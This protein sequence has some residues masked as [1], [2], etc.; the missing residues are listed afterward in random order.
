MSIT[1]PQDWVIKPL[2]ELLVS[3]ESGS[4]PKGGV[5]G[6]ESGVPSL[7]GEHLDSNGGFKFEKIKYVP[8]A[9]AAKMTRGRIQ[10]GDILI[11]KDGATTGKTSFVGPSFP[12]ADA[13]INEHVFS[14]RCQENI[15]PKYIFYFL[16]SAEGNRQILEDF[17]GAAQGGISQR[18]ADIVN[19]PLAPLDQQKRIVAE[20]E[21][22][23]SRLDEA[24]ANLK[25][26]KAN[27]K[28]YKATVLKAAVEGR[29]VETE[30]SIARREGRSLPTP[31]PGVFYVYAIRCIDD[32]IYIGHTDNLARRWEEHL[33][34]QG[35]DWTKQHKPIQIVRYE[36]YTSRQEA[37]DREKWLKTGYGRKWIKRE[38]EAGRTRQVGY[39]TGEQLLQRILDTRRQQWLARAEQAGGKGKGKYKEPSAPDTT[40]L[41]ELPEGWVVADLEQLTSSERIIC[42]GIL[43]PKENVPDGVLYVKVRDMKGDK[44]DMTSLQRTSP[45][46]AAKY[47][48]ASLKT[49]DILLAIRGT[50]GRIAEVPPELDG[51]NITQDTAR[52]AVSPLMDRNYVAWF[53]RSLVAQ[54]FFKKVARGVAVKGVN[55]ADV[56]VCPVF[57]PSLPEQRRIVAEVERRLSIVDEVADQ[58]DVNLMRADR[59][60]Q[61]VLRRSFGDRFSRCA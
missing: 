17:R 49:G 22:Q 59:L 35:A 47:T 8:K 44:V 36:E 42:Y 6:I 40:D 52:L 56:R 48:K 10:H 20:I 54:N 5:K 15:E 18:F 26:V 60:R 24:V 13:V 31:R 25:R 34:G 19:V 55:I 7:G 43:M 39:E 33:A 16:Y 11:V 28:R 23:L 3:F 41:P 30:A 51:G 9:F 53:L 45:D 2:R 14:C 29:L 27:L 50:Y 46:I 21:K 37:S 38:I 61:A 4:R 32:S 1:L 57:L 58:A 12:Y